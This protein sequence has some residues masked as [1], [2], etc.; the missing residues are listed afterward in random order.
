MADAGAE[1]EVE[2]KGIE[3]SDVLTKYKTAGDMASRVLK[4]VRS[5]CVAGK[6]TI[7][8]CKIG[9]EL[10]LKETSAVYNKQKDMKKGIAMPTCLSVNN[11]VCHNRPIDSDPEIVLADGDVVKIDLAVHLD[12]Y[13]APVASTLVVGEP[14]VTG[15]KAD[16]IMAAYTAAEVALRMMRPGCKTY[17][18]SDAI[19]KVADAFGCK[20][21][22]GFLSHQ[23]SKNKIDGEKAVIQNP[24]PQLK[25]E[26]KDSV[27]EVNEVY[28]I[29]ILMS[30]GQ[31]KTKESEQ[32]TTVFRKMPDAIYQLKMKAS[33][34]FFS[35]VSKNFDVMPFQLGA[36][37][38]E[39]AA[40]LG[41]TE[42]V[43][44]DLVQP[45]KI[46]LEEDGVFVAQFKLL[47]LITP[48]GNLRGTADVDFNAAAVKSER[49]LEDPELVTLLKTTVG[50]K[51]KK[52]NKKKKKSA[53]GAEATS[54]SPAES[55][56]D[57]AAAK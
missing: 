45:F 27:I 49:T 39:K 34:Q 17:A 5:E 11:C 35:E 44:H 21:V 24:T 8:I 54:V 40:R 46:L 33:R 13:I 4:A 47:V 20:A 1:E 10:I 30:T 29:D 50:S 23:L 18:V 42:C 6:R 31:G 19:T 12:G 57:G 38:D 51:N 52:K 25:K 28:G 22:E 48:N 2:I 53:E 43:K 26:H 14:Q 7:D 3:D 16:V 36:L 32:R 56:A 37:S 15:P 55:P 9:D 41:V